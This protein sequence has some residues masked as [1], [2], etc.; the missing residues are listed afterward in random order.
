MT[1]RLKLLTDLGHGGMG[2]VW[3]APDEET[4][5][6]IAEKSMRET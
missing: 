3:K 5:S 1:E 6:I 2:I 4:G